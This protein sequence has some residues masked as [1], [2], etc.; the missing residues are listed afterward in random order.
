MVINLMLDQ[1]KLTTWRTTK[2]SDWQTFK[3]NAT[4]CCTW[5][6]CTLEMGFWKS[7]LLKKLSLLRVWARKA[8]N[9]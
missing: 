4:K 3:Q 5:K 9:I 1:V 8:H 7:N 2:K 6:V